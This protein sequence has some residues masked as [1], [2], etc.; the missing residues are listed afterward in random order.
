MKLR[1]FVVTGN[2]DKDINIMSNGRVIL[3]P[4]PHGNQNMHFLMMAKY[5]LTTKNATTFTFLLSPSRHMF[6]YQQYNVD[7]ELLDCLEI[8]YNLID[9]LDNIRLALETEKGLTP[10]IH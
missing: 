2:R 7:E 3:F 4:M 8:I 9:F 6:P 5:W 1:L 10:I